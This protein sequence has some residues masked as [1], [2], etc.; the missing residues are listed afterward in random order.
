MDSPKENDSPE[1]AQL[2][3][4]YDVLKTDAKTIVDDLQ[5]GVRMWREAAGANAA[6]AG[7]I[8]VLALTTFRYGPAGPEGTAIIA[9]QLVLAV[10]LLGFSAFG[11]RKYFELSRRYRGLFQRAEKLG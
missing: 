6:A 11:F 9:A 5:G 1:V 10:V 2:S 8:L 4:I 7:F 3:E